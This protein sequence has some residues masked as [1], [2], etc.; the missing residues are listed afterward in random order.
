[1]GPGTCVGIVAAGP[2]G[3][4]GGVDP[5]AGSVGNPVSAPGGGPGS[6]AGGVGVVA[7]WAIDDMPSSTPTA[8]ASSRRRRLRR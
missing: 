1:P 8:T 3:C 2:S 7:A 4:A 5:L 6:E